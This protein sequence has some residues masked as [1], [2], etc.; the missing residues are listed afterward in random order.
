MNGQTITYKSKEAGKPWQSNTYI[1]SP[2]KVWL[3]KWFGFK[4]GNISKKGYFG[5]KW[6]TTKRLE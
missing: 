6:I 3:G 1:F 4:A 5:T 2:F